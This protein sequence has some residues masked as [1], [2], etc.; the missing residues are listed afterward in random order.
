[1][2][3]TQHISISD[4][5]SP[6]NLIPNHNCLRSKHPN[7]VTI[8]YRNINSVRKKL[9]QSNTYLGKAINILMIAETKL[10]ETFPDSQFKVNG[11]KKQYRFDVSANSGGILV[12]IDTNISSKS[13]FQ[14]YCQLIS[15]L[16]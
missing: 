7:N 6:S 9:D 2:Q 11:P 13:F 15:K 16:F 3:T 8:A 1:M 5:T 10:D 14:N 12:Y 4:C